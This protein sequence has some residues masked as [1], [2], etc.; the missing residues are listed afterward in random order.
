MIKTITVRGLMGLSFCWI[1]MQYIKIENLCLIF[2]IYKIHYQI[3]FED[4]KG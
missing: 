1:L 3:E 4:T 2:I